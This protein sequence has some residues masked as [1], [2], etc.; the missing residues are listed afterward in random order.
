MHGMCTPVFSTDLCL[1]F[2]KSAASF[3]Q[4]KIRDEP[5]TPILIT[6]DL[7][8][9]CYLIGLIWSW[10]QSIMHRKKKK[11]F[12]LMPVQPYLNVKKK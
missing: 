4:I 12:F 10:F 5:I 9:H 2:K 8:A 6:A 11:I 1:P 7:W 3:A